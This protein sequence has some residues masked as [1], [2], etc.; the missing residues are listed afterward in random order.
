M[1]TAI[2]LIWKL[3]LK[4]VQRLVIYDLTVWHPG[5]WSVLGSSGEIS[6]ISLVFLRQQKAKGILA[7]CQVTGPSSVSRVATFCNSAESA[8]CGPPD[9]VARSRLHLVR[10]WWDQRC[11]SWY[12][13]TVGDLL[14][15][16]VLF[17]FVCFLFSKSW[18]PVNGLVLV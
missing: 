13:Y 14:F 2:L 1:I 15:A 8:H 16:S 12:L 7:S 4:G 6:W 17:L 3:G 18:E 5:L 11:W 9:Q 10:P